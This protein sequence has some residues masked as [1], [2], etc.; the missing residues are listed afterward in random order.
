MPRDGALI[1]SDLTGKLDVLV[2]WCRRSRCMKPALK[3][4]IAVVALTLGLAA[5]VVAGS[6]DEDAIL[7]KS[8]ARVMFAFSRPR[9]GECSCRCGY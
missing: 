3:H 6:P 9:G 2:A 4:V 8:D 7:S 5:P 1:F